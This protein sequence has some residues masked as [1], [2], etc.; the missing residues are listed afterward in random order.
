MTRLLLILPLLLVAM[1]GC[2]PSKPDAPG[3][4]GGGM[5]MAMPMA[6]D[7]AATRGYKSSMSTMMDKMPTYT[8]DADIDF[9]LQM[10]GHHQ[11]AIDMANVELA[12]GKDPEARA[13]AKSIIAAQKTEIAQMGVWLGKKGH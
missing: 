11:A 6:G 8:G 5:K 12:N 4:S 1:S 7:S 9:M 10:R 13:L 2:S 3:G